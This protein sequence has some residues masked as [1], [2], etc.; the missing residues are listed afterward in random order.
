M[1]TPVAEGAAAPPIRLPD[2]TGDV[3]DLEV[4]RGRWVVVFFYPRAMTSGCTKEA[5]GVR[6]ALGELEELGA[7]VWGVSD[8]PQDKLVRFREK[9]GLTFPLL[10]DLGH[11]VAEAYGVYGVKK[12]GGKE[13][14]GVHRMTFLVDPDGVVARVWKRVKP[15][16]HPADVLEELRSRT[17]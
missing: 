4:H 1:P 8:D 6:D 3:V 9:Q 15:A 10:S 11:E 5:C 14:M 2:D 7:V 13:R 17:G 12:S 16:G